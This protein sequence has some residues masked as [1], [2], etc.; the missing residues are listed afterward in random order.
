MSCSSEGIIV[1]LAEMSPESSAQGHDLHGPL[2]CETVITTN[3]FKC[4]IEPH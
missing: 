4:V 1:V 2:L 3:Q